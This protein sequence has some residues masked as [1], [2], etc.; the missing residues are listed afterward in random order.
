ML[1]PL[2]LLLP[3]CQEPDLAPNDP[4]EAIVYGWDAM[5][6]AD[7]ERAEA[8]FRKAATKSGADSQD[9]KLAVFGLA[10]SFQHRKPVSDYDTAEKFYSELVAQDKGHDVGAWSALA[11]ARMHHLKLYEPG[12]NSDDTAASRAFRNLLIVIV[13]FSLLAVGSAYAL[14][15]RSKWLGLSAVLACAFVGTRIGKEFMVHETSQRSAAGLPTVV[16]LDKIR[17]RFAR[18]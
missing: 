6:S 12:R 3:A 11:I 7:Y 15:Q 18:S 10:N 17:R 5:S 4:H 16:E 9:H 13:G 14:L 8:A 1:L 2:L